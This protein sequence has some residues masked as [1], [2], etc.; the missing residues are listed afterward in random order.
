M[1]KGHPLRLSNQIPHKMVGISDPRLS[2]STAEKAKG[3]PVRTTTIFM[4][5]KLANN[6][7]ITTTAFL[8]KINNLFFPPL[9]VAITYK[10]LTDTT[11]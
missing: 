1:R 2:H 9:M 6:D 5:I 11:S 10:I 8:R 3:V 4:S 7:N